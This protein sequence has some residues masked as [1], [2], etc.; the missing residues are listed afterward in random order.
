M[1]FKYK[2]V[3]INNE[4]VLYLYSTS[5]YEFASIDIN[6]NLSMPERVDNY[7]KNSGIKFTGNKV[8]LVIDGIIAGNM[9]YDSRHEI[10]SE[11]NKIVPLEIDKIDVL[12]D[13]D[14]KRIDYYD[15]EMII[16]L[17][18][19]DT[20]VISLT[21]ED[22]LIGTIAYEMP[23]HYESEALKA[24]AIIA[25]TY[26]IKE[27]FIHKKIKAVNSTQIYKDLNYFKFVW[28][29]NYHSNLNK[30]IL[31]IKNTNGQ[32]LTYNKKI[33]SPKF[34]PISNGKTEDANSLG[35]GNIPYLISLPSVWDMEAT[36]YIKTTSKEISDISLALNVSTEDLKKI[37]I[38][39]VTKGN[40]IKT[41]KIGDKIFTGTDLRYLLNLSSNDISILI[42]KNNVKLVTRGLG[43][44]L[45]LSQ[46]GANE[47]I[48]DGA[49]H[50]DVLK[51]YFPNTKIWKLV[52][53][54][55]NHSKLQK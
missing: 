7:V 28:G 51:Y 29:D 49:D 15:G 11:F 46:F 8:Y 53:E 45:G 20:S 34:H 47:M 4:E 2:I 52:R 6:S 14:R 24:Q 42:N 1:F 44:G 21:L 50:I 32:Y 30:I 39:E 27:M 16:N 37:T 17:E 26:A 48:K 41:I 3:K 54:V 43:T 13:N 18:L 38:L 10:D 25:R 35:L 40:Q 36:N 19:E 9:T 33:I 23:I 22:Y 5:N 55:Y 31:A 12:D